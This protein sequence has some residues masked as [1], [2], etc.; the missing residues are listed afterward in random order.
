ME[1]SRV[2]AT[3]AQICA[4]VALLAGVYLLAGLAWTLVT[5]AL[6]VGTLSVLI[7]YL[8]AR[9]PRPPVAPAPGGDR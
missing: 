7:E 6:V 2:A 3:V 1:A 9:S 4:L 8:A 5:G